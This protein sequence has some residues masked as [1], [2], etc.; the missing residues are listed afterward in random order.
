MHTRSEP[1]AHPASPMWWTCMSQSTGV[2]PSSGQVPCQ[3]GMPNGHASWYGAHLL[4]GT[5]LVLCD[6]C[7]CTLP[8]GFVVHSLANFSVLIMTSLCVQVPRDTRSSVSVVIFSLCHVIFSLHAV[9]SQLMYL[10]CP[11]TKIHLSFSLAA[12]VCLILSQCSPSLHQTARGP[13]KLVLR[14]ASAM[15]NNHMSP[16]S[17]QPYLFCPGDVAVPHSIKFF[18]TPHRSWIGLFL[19]PY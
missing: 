2:V 9:L 14:M 6:Q 16:F 19:I 8:C 1:A 13:R 17:S 11:N 15:G 18:E 7:A 10:C 4:L 3:L 12:C 5:M